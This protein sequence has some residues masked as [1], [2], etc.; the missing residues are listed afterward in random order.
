MVVGSGN[1]HNSNRSSTDSVGGAGAAAP[2]LVEALF[3]L[4]AEWVKELPVPSLRLAC[5]V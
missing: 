3:K 2:E 4:M 1:E 5:R